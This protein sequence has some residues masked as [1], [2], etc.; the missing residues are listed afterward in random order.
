MSLLP[1]PPLEAPQQ[2][3]PGSVTISYATVIGSG[4]PLGTAAVALNPGATFMTVTYSQFLAQVGV[5]AMPTD[6]RKNC[7]ANIRVHVPQGWTFAIEKTD[8]RGYANLQA[9]AYGIERANYYFQGMSQTAYIQHQ[10]NGPFQNDWQT[11]DLVGIAALV[12]RPCGEDR[13]FNIN[14]QLA[15]YPGWSNPHTT[16]SYITM[17]S[18]DVNFSTIYHFAWRRCP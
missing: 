4:C 1:H 10:F 11:T 18:T 9:G 7:Q 2:P 8:Y 17:D 13:N 15:V 3:P 12:F 5:G 14:A 6:N 16:N